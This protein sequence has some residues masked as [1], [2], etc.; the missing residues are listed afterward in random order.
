[1][2]KVS[3]Q[4]KFAFRDK[5]NLTKDADLRQQLFQQVLLR[6]AYLTNL[7]DLPFVLRKLCST[8]VAYFSQPTS[9][10]RLPVRGVL[11]AIFEHGSAA[12]FQHVR[13]YGT[14]DVAALM[15]PMETI[16]YHQLRGILW[17]SLS[18]VEDVSRSDPKSM[19]GYDSVIHL[20]RSSLTSG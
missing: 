6:Y 4:A 9:E 20:S 18:L 19:E 1:M 11:A 17:L 7:P 15:P 5:D 2:F 3:N 8:L 14:S 16:T 13:Q 12:Q 10:W